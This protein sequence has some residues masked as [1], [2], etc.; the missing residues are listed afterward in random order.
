[1]KRL[2]LWL[3]RRFLWDEFALMYRDGYDD[4]RCAVQH[5]VDECVLTGNCVDGQAR[6]CIAIEQWTALVLAATPPEPAK[7]ATP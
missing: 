2:L 7:G 3:A 1:M 6:V 5:L 4:G